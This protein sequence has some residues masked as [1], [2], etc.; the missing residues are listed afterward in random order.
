M[1]FFPNASAVRDFDGTWA[2]PRIAYLEHGNDPVV[3]MD[4]SIFYKKPEWLSAGQR[5]PDIS[6][7]M[8][9]IPLVTG[10]QGLADMAMAEGVPD[11][12]GHRYADATFYAW[13]KV[14][15]DGGLDQAALDRIQDVIDQYDTAAPIGQ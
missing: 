7:Q 15:G 10:L 2:A 14:T 11:D 8:V 12:A 5:S 9:F 6:E 13:I 4:W 1:Q 3:W